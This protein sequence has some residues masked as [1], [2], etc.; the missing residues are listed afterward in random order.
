L[1]SPRN[2]TGIDMTNLH[3]SS[4]MKQSQTD[5][6]VWNDPARGIMMP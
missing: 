4:L 5:L 1:K 3:R 2:S 6:M